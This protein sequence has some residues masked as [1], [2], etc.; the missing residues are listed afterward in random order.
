LNIIVCVKQVPIS[1]EVQIDPET[2]VLQRA[3]IE[4]KINPY[5]LFAV[6]EALRLRKRFGGT[7]TAFTMGPPQAEEVIRECYYMGADHGVILTDKKFAG[8]DVWATAYALSQGILSLG[9]YDLIICGKQTTDGD[10]AQ[11][12]PEVAEILDI[13]HAANVTSVNDLMQNTG[14]LSIEEER[15][16]CLQSCRITLPCLLTVSKDLNEP[17]LPSYKKMK[18][19]GDKEIQKL[20]FADMPDPDPVHYGLE[21][22]PTRVARVFPPEH[23]T[24]HVR[25]DGNFKEVMER[26]YEVLVNEKFI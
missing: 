26:F 16:N 6:E 23:H 25:Y 15:D 1:T 7:V 21:G 10:T 5:D 11:V 12:G 18:L 24:E 17:R 4:S 20:S 8:A 22:S 3:G 13:P 19:Y 9:N 14:K 2:G